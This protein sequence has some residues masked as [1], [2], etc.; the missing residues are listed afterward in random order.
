MHET[1]ET[2]HLKLEST[3]MVLNVLSVD[4]LR[5]NPTG[6]VACVSTRSHR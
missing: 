1:A 5:S 3:P 2:D 6:M 4:R